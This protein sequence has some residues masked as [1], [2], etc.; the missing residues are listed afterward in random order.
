MSDTLSQ[1]LVAYYIMESRDAQ[2]KREN[3]PHEKSFPFLKNQE[4]EA[5]LKEKFTGRQ[6]VKWGYLIYSGKR[7]RWTGLITD[8]RDQVLILETAAYTGT[9]AEYFVSQWRMCFP[10]PDG[11]L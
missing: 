8:R 1:P 11:E 7:K 9:A 6:E 3:Q 4:K 2:Q 10:S 5:I